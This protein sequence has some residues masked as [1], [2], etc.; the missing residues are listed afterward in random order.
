MKRPLSLAKNLIKS[1]LA[2]AGVYIYENGSQISDTDVELLQIDSSGFRFEDDITISYLSFEK[3]W[4]MSAGGHWINNEWRTVYEG[5]GTRDVGGCDVFGV[6]FSRTQREYK[7]R[8]VRCSG[9]LWDADMEHCKETTSR[10]DNDGSTGFGFALQDES[11]DGL[12]NSYYIGDIWTASCTYDANFG[13]YAGYATP[14]Y[15][16][17]CNNT[18]INLNSISFTIENGAWKMNYT[19]TAGTDDDCFEIFGSDTIFGVLL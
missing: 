11:Y 15:F 17:S 8:V 10:I 19:I 1:E 13:N 5:L 18:T 4:L 6:K 7:S 16:H 9:K 2:N 14:Y 3:T 12:F